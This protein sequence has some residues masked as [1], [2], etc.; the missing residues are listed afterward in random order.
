MPKIGDIYYQAFAQLTE[1]ERGYGS[2][3]WIKERR[4]TGVEQTELGTT[5]IRFNNEERFASDNI[6]YYKTKEEA[7]FASKLKE[8]ELLER[9]IALISER[10]KLDQEEIKDYQVAL[11][12]LKGGEKTK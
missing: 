6:P 4:V 12:K 8:K 10:I 7:I 2:D 5:W 1:G 9:E 3:S 11:E